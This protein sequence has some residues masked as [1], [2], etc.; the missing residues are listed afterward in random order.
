MHGRSEEMQEL[1]EAIL[2]KVIPRLLRPLETGGREIQPRIVHGDLWDGN[3]STNAVTDKPLIFDASSM[4]AHNEFELGAW[5]MPRHQIYKAYIRAYQK[6]FPISEPEEDV[7]DRL[8]L[9]RLRF[10]LTSSGCYLDNLKFRELVVEDMR[11]LLGKYP[12]GYE[13]SESQKQEIEAH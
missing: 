5:N 10:N 9:Y 11:Y 4:Y 7:D 1:F 6:C 3:T 8:I 13:G 12:N 2:K